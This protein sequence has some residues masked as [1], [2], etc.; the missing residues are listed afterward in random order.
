MAYRTYWR[1]VNYGGTITS[2][3][4]LTTGVF[5]D[6]DGSKLTYFGTGTQSTSGS[7]DN[8]IEIDLGRV[9]PIERIV[10]HWDARDQRQFYRLVK[11]SEDGVNWTYVVGSAGTFELSPA[12]DAGKKIAEDV[13]VLSPAVQARYV[14]IYANGNTVSVDNAL[15]VVRV[16]KALGRTVSAGAIVTR[17][18]VD[19]VYD[20][21]KDW[22][23]AYV[24]TP[25][26]KPSWTAPPEPTKPYPSKSDIDAIRAKIEEYAG[27]TLTWTEI[28]PGQTPLSASIENE[29]VNALQSVSVAPV[30]A[31]CDNFT[32]DC[33]STCYGYAA[34]SCNSTCYS[35]VACSCNSTCHGYSCICNTS[36]NNYT[37]PTSSCGCNSSC[38][39][40][41][42][43]VLSISSC[44]CNVSDYY[45]ESGASALA[46]QCRCYNAAFFGAGSAGVS[47]GGCL[48]YTGNFLINTSVKKCQCYTNNYNVSGFCFCYNANHGWFTWRKTSCTCNSTCYG[49]SCSCNS[50]CHGYV[51]CSCD[52]TCYGES[53]SLCHSVS[54][55]V[56]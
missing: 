56:D 43:P 21:L 32:C 26:Q 7:E 2:A 20:R 19:E 28:V 52:A 1:G 48:C 25:L 11:V 16:Q 44:G 30:C 50:T 49:Y 38:Y 5:Y 6:Q 36:C 47:Y 13:I 37:W 15:Y 18:V 27:A 39:L 17:E 12:P 53:C 10:I 3:N 8:Y 42:T 46:N 22:Y 51:A 31:T 35:Y 33:E 29:L 54:Y 45:T 9:R 23:H 55:S 41:N 24:E 14:R 40:N 4:N 34:C